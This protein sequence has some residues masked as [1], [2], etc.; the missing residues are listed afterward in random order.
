MHFKSL[1]PPFCLRNWVATDDAISR[2]GRFVV[3]QNTSVFLKGKAQ[4]L[5]NEQG[6]AKAW[7]SAYGSEMCART[8]FCTC[9]CTCLLAIVCPARA[10][11]C[12]H[13][14]LLI[15]TA[16]VSPFKNKGLPASQDPFLVLYLRVITCH[17]LHHGLGPRM[18]GFILAAEHRDSLRHFWFRD[19]S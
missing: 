18:H 7:G 13:Y 11:P 16:C 12:L 1:L 8:S 9:L 19:R 5:N 10:S 15:V 17:I 4:P 3:A 2:V 14:V 6:T